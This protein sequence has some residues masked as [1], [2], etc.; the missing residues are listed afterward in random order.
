M[1]EPDNLPPDQAAREAAARQRFFALTLFRLS[2]VALVMFGFAVMLQRFDWV[3]GDKAKWM[4]AIFACV[5]MFQTLMVPR[6]L[7]RAWRTPDQ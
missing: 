4:G 5:G 6:L 7:S 2:G 1:M 3:Q